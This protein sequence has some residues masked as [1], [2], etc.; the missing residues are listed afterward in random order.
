MVRGEECK[1]ALA[2]EPYPNQH[3][4]KGP[5]AFAR[6][7]RLPILHPIGGILYMESNRHTLERLGTSKVM[8]TIN[9]AC[10]SWFFALSRPHVYCLSMHACS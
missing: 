2:L 9:S 6:V 4:V 1:K 5:P 8:R 10:G 7:E 3:R